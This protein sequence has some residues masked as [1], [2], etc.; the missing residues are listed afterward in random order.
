MENGQSNE[1]KRQ[2]R[3]AFWGVVS[4]IWMSLVIVSFLVIRILG[5]ET[6]RALLSRWKA[7]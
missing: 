3:G 7:H 5:S 6:A 4:E 1:G 2:P